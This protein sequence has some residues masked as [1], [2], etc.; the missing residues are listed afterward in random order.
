MLG[1]PTSSWGAQ[2]VLGDQRLGSAPGAAVWRELGSIDH[3]FTH[4]SLTLDVFGAETGEA[5]SN[6]IWWSAEA[7]LTRLPTV[8]RKVLELGLKALDP[9]A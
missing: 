1:L 4:F 6:V 2:P 7:A 9:S 5:W 3:V 8:F